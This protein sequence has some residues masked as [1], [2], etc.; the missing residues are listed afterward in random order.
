[1]AQPVPSGHRA[2]PRA[3]HDLRRQQRLPADFPVPQTGMIA[4]AAPAFPHLLASAASVS[5]QRGTPARQ[6]AVT[7]N[8]AIQVTIYNC[9]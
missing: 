4:A 5:V 8:D 3:R 2:A 9:R 1:M 6:T 7:C